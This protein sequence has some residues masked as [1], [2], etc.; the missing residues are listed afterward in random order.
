MVSV[1]ETMK[2]YSAEDNLTEEA[3]VAKIR[4]CRC[5]HLFLHTSL[6]NNSSGLSYVLCHHRCGRRV[7]QSVD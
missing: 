6:R 4:T 5:H 1:L 3:L 2:T 7:L